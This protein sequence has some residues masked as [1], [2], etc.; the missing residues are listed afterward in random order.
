MTRKRIYYPQ[1]QI[2]ENLYTP[3]KEY[4]T[5]DNIEYIG[6]YHRYIDGTVM[7]GAVYDKVESKV[8]KTYVDTV[9]QPEIAVYRDSIKQGRFSKS[10]VV[11]SVQPKFVYSAPTVKDFEIGKFK[12]YFIRRR[13]FTGLKDIYEIDADQY[14]LWKQVKSGIDENIYDAIAI[15][16]K[17]VGPLTDI[18]EDG[19]VID[20]GVATTNERIVR[21]NSIIFT[22]LDSYITNFIEFSTYSPLCPQDIKNKFGYLTN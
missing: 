2:I 15:D 11:Y 8:L 10:N 6:F 14:K 22:G 21:S 17:L 13:N 20:P 7:T 5:V 9:T 16:W 19:I 18:V 3:G 4:M 1:S 12:R